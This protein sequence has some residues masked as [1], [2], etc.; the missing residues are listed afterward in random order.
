MK[1]TLGPCEGLAEVQLGVAGPY[2]SHLV[3]WI[4]DGNQ[5]VAF[6]TSSQVMLM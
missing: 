2:C 4:W 5:E 3:Q 6:L 1:V